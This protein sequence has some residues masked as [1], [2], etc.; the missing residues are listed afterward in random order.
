M[1]ILKDARA[2]LERLANIFVK[3]K[4]VMLVAAV[5]LFLMAWPFGREEEKNEAE[6]VAGAQALETDVT[7]LEEKLVSLLKQAEG[8]GRVEVMLSLASD[9]E[10]VYAS[11]QSRS[12]DES[13]ADGGASSASLEESTKYASVRLEDG[14][15]A[16]VVLKRVYPEYKGAVV[17]CDGADH[18]GVRLKVINA[19]SALTGLS[20]D[21]ITV[22]KMK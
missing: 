7:A 2:Y 5:G 14:S 16:L 4:Y 21:R 20:S 19:V 17:V 1:S 6:P 8:V 13:S 9:M 15:E 18:A 22:M 12:L 10:Y 11:E 3:Y